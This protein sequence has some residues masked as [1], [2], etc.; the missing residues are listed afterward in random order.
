MVTKNKKALFVVLLAIA[1]IAGC[2]GNNGD[3]NN[4]KRIEEDTPPIEAVE[5]S[6]PV[7][8]NDAGDDEIFDIE[9]YP[10]EQIEETPNLEQTVDIE[11]P[12]PHWQ[13]A[14]EEFLSEYN[15]I[16]TPR[17]T[18]GNEWS[19][20]EIGGWWRFVRE[21]RYICQDGWERRVF[22]L[23]DPMTEEPVD[24]DTEPYVFVLEWVG[25]DGTEQASIYVASYF[26]LKDVSGD[27]IPELFI[28]W[29][30]IDGDPFGFTRMFRYK[31][32]RYEPVNVSRRHLPLHWREEI[33]NSPILFHWGASGVNES[34]AV[35]SEGRIFAIGMGGAAGIESSASILKLNK[36]GVVLEPIFHMRYGHIWDE[37]N[38]SEWGFRL[39]IDES[40]KKEHAF[41]SDEID[42]NDVAFF[43]WQWFQGE[44]DM[45]PVQL[46]VLPDITV[47]PLPRMRELEERVTER[48]TARLIL[49]G[50]IVS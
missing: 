23:V 42:F 12:I 5:G 31:D 20:W 37:S 3:E 34:L 44:G 11:L 2:N 14:L 40:I 25:W 50:R 13:V 26:Y 35:D 18:R 32:G 33:L 6:Y 38:G 1:I 16:F 9:T 15:T 39:Y 45:T 41:L 17:T 21:C 22:Y 19:E 27:G 36:D 30:I 43:P 28:S 7:A 24:A 46:P 48:I 49:E 10:P 29:N 47:S 8:E 4:D